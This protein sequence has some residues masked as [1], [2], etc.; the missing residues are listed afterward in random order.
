MVDVVLPPRLRGA[1]HLGA[2]IGLP[3]LGAALIA[4]GHDTGARIASA[5]YTLGVTA[6]YAVSATYHRGRWTPETK[7]KL[8][9]LDHSTILVSIAATYTPLTVVGLDGAAGTPLLVAVWTLTAVGV[10]VRNLWLDAPR[11]LA[12]AVYLAVGWLSVLAMPAMW[13]QIGPGS[14]MLIAVGGLAYSVGAVV[15]ARQRPDPFPT[16]FGYHEVFHALVVIAGLLMYAAEY[17]VVSAR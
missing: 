16:T 17:R 2:A 6:M 7:R 9:R 4:A 14:T 11:W 15:Y 13:D 3:L 5:V 12:V 8:R 1:S 10:V